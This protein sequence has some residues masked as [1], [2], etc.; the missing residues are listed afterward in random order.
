MI[1]L[2]QITMPFGTLRG[3]IRKAML[4]HGGPYQIYMGK[5]KWFD[6]DKIY[7]HHDIFRVKPSVVGVIA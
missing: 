6:S 1:D 3:K 2:T 7:A 4:A 5:D